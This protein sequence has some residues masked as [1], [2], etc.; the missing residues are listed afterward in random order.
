[1]KISEQVR[2]QMA[3]TVIEH[4]SERTEEYQRAVGAIKDLLD[5][6]SEPNQEKRNF[7]WAY[8][9]IV[10]L[11]KRKLKEANETRENEDDWP[12]G[13]E[14]NDLAGT[15]KSIFLHQAREEAGIPHDEFL[16]GIRSG[17]YEVDDLYE[18]P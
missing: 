2:L 9:A 6:S 11:A 18:K 15:S 4:H 8:A 14:W 12:G 10:A 17:E 5:E 7:R 16:E 13:Q 1:M 3:L